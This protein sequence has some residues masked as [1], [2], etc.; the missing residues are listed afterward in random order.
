MELG[1]NITVSSNANEAAQR[2]CTVPDFREVSIRIAIA[3]ETVMQAGIV[4]TAAPN[5]LSCRT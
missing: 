4:A 3:I 5:R 1:F 2:A